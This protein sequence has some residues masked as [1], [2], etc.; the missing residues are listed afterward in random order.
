MSL[1]AAG[2]DVSGSSNPRWRGGLLSKRCQVCSVEY[3]V[4]QAQRG[5][6]F[7]ITSK[8]IIERDGFQCHGINCHGKDDRLTTHH[9]NYNKLDCSDINLIALCRSCNSRANFGRDLWQKTYSEI[10]AR[11]VAA[12]LI[13]PS[14]TA[15]RSGCAGNG[16]AARPASPELGT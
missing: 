6:R 2:L 8:S 11:R 7:S 12:G 3:T 4:K 16:E 10:M 14:T 13:H 15:A 5:S 9:F 1:N